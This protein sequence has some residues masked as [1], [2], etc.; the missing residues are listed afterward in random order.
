MLFYL[1]V[2]YAADFGLSLVD[3]TTAS[4]TFEL[5]VLCTLYNW[6]FEDPVRAGS[7]SVHGR[8]NGLG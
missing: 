2:R 3:R 5:G 7:M 8:G 6:H 1:E 4:S